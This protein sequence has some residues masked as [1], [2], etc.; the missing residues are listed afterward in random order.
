MCGVAAVVSLRNPEENV[1]KLVMRLVSNIQN[2]GTD[3]VGLGAVG[4]IG[5]PNIHWK[6]VGSAQDNFNKVELELIEEE[7][8]GSRPIAIGHVRY[9]T[10]SERDKYNAQPHF[11]GLGGQRFVIAS[12][13]DIPFCDEERAKLI[14][15]GKY[16]FESTCDSEVIAKLIGDAWFYNNK[17][18]E[19]A[20][21][22]VGKTL[23]GAF[24][25][26]AITPSKRLFIMRDSLGFRPLWYVIDKARE[27]LYV[28]SESAV[29][30]KI[31]GVIPLEV[32]P[33]ELIV[34]DPFHP[35]KQIT[36]YN[37]SDNSVPRF[38]LMELYYFTRPD[39]RYS[40]TDPRTMAGIRFLFGAKLAEEW[41][42]LGYPRPD[43]ICPLPFS[44]NPA[45]EGFS[46]VTGIPCIGAISKDRFSSPRIFMEDDISREELTEEKLNA[47]ADFFTGILKIIHVKTAL[48]IDDSI[49]RGQQSRR[50]I[51][52]LRRVGCQEV[53]YGSTAYL[54]SYPCFFGINTP[55]RN[56][57]IAN[58]RT[59]E[60]VR[61][62][63]G[64]D[65]LYYLSLEG[66]YQAI[67]HRNFCDA[68]FTGNYPIPV[69]SAG[70]KEV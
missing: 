18:E 25:L 12:N 61:K 27:F 4:L 38:C 45:A 62:E 43:I 50:V 60:E 21:L 9:A 49:V 41:G 67:G 44:G 14:I 42:N 65:E 1:M 53:Y 17:N 47:I 64:A 7:F 54:Y 5:K 15:E 11:C 30:Q 68:C 29:I 3:S 39:S 70:R 16:Q 58:N 10:A 19:D 66:T 32:M 33:G 24:S 22:R 23:Q 51:E 55:D 63:I 8:D 31:T 46:F 13:G 20:F 52:L 35:T 56:H 28:C 2:R 40:A 34:V 37:F 48:V 26:V 69:P 57:L 36:K 59:M 6:K